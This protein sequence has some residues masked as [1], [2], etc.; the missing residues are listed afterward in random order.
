M[1]T[2]VS[3]F[4]RSPWRLVL[5]PGGLAL[6][7]FLAR[8][9]VFSG[10]VNSE[11]TAIILVAILILFA[12]WLGW[13][14]RR[15]WIAP[16]HLQRAEAL[17]SM[18]RPSHGVL[19]ALE[20]AS[21]YLGELG[22]RMHQLRGYALLSLKEKERAR[23]A[24]REASLAR[25]PF[26]S[27]WPVRAY[28]RFVS[29]KPGQRAIWWGL[30][31]L[32]IAPRMARLRHILGLH[33]HL[34]EGP[35][36]QQ[37]AWELL[38][39]TVPLAAD[40]P[41]LLE[42]LMTLGL[43][44][45]QSLDIPSPHL[46][47]QELHPELPYIFEETL[48]L[49]LQRHGDPR[50]GWDRTLPARHLALKGRHREVA[51]LAM[52]VPPVLR[53]AALWE[54][55]ASSLKSLG[56]SQG[57]HKVLEDALEYQPASFR[58]WM[59]KFQFLMEQQRF[60]EGLEILEQ[61]RRLL[62]VSGQETHRWEWIAQRA[63]YAHWIDKDPDR[64]WEFLEMIPESAPG[65]RIP[66]LRAQVLTALGRYEE[67]HEILRA[68]LATHAQDPELQLLQAEI[69]AGMEAWRALLPYLE[70]CSE[71][72]RSRADFWHLQGLA[73]AHLEDRAKA[74]ETLERAATMARD[75]ARFILD[76][77]HACMD[78]SE[79]E[80]AEQ[81]WRQ[82]LKVDEKCEEALVQLAET[83]RALHD[84]EGAK[85]L[86]RECLLHYPESEEAQIVLAEME[87]N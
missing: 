47:I 49:L 73:Q 68:Q 29:G 72:L 74:R 28:F 9:L 10:L 27:R 8:G 55:L 11:L 52:G 71:T 78:L 48:D 46:G 20:D 56:D 81:H 38:V 58:L 23:V 14:I 6:S 31:L 75:N 17:W 85:R 50:I 82:A 36:N 66:L 35:H 45:I 19:R 2:L 32:R 4:L 65:G 25:L 84:E 41:L 7:L 42:E 60:R 63:G 37:K 13:W 40:D 80:R 21:L 76:A 3:S 22:Y 53:S 70:Q 61:A 33:L 39:E 59:E 26:W 86:L 57:L 77:G 43:A 5:W 51:N 87:A 67:A 44:R 62:P 83:R 30:R 64:A 34:A 54:V 69:L 15:T 1:N 18:G 16:S 12:L 24:F 79:F